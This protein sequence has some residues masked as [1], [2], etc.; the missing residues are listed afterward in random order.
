MYF[1][2]EDKIEVE[3]EFVIK[4]NEIVVTIPENLDQRVFKSKMWD[5]YTQDVLPVE[6]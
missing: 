5:E 1:N 6:V 4:H 2:G 3:P